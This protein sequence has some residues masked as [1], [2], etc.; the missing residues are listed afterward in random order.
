LKRNERKEL[1]KKEE[2]KKTKDT[3]THST[4]TA[5]PILSFSPAR[6]TSPSPSFIFAQPNNQPAHLTPPA[7]SPPSRH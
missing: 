1:K 2:E 3:L 6:P 4:L 7:R 5:Q